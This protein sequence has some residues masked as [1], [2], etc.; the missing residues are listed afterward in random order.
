MKR[1]PEASTAGEDHRQR[2]G[3]RA[4]GEDGGEGHATP[5]PDPPTGFC[6]KRK[7]AAFS[8]NGH[9][10]E[11]PFL[12]LLLKPAEIMSQKQETSRREIAADTVMGQVSELPEGPSRCR[13]APEGLLYCGRPG[14]LQL[15]A[16]VWG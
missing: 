13:T 10:R 15:P 5:P 12:A 9:F 4:Q 14:Q 2:R 16:A 6:M 8:K 7:A 11:T 3:R 1:Y